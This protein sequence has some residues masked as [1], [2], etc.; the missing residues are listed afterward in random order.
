MPKPSRLAYSPI[1]QRLVAALNDGDWHST[2]E[3]AQAAHICAVDTYI[4]T[5][6]AAPNGLTIEHRQRGDQ[7]H[8]RLTPQGRLTA[9]LAHAEQLAEPC[10]HKPGARQAAQEAASC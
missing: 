7:H 5:L 9:L 1:L 3:L 10:R 8:Y 6:R 2:F 4:R